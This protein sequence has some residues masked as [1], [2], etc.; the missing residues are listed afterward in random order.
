MIRP[1]RACIVRAC[2]TRSGAA[3]KRRLLTLMVST[4]HDG[5]VAALKTNAN[6]N[7]ESETISSNNATEPDNAENASPAKSRKN[8]VEY[9][10]LT[11]AVQQLTETPRTP[12]TKF[13]P[14]AM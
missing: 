6:N 2:D 7:C 12:P 10:E 11:C 14:T 5:G 13:A 3:R 8:P 9:M 4:V 1:Y